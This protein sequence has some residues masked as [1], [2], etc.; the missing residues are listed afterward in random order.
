M[1]TVQIEINGT[2]TTVETNILGRM[3]ADAARN[4]WMHVAKNVRV[5]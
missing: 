2:W 5:I 3:A 1:F 4:G